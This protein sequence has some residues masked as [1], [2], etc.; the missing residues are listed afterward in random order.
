MLGRV[1]G[2]VKCFLSLKSPKTMKSDWGDWKKVSCRG[3]PIFIAVGV[4]SRTINLR[5][6]NGLCYKLT[7][8]ALFTYLILYRVEC[9][10]STVLSSAYFTHFSNLNRSGTNADIS[11][12]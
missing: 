4:A 11:K 6:F 1:C 10:I 12:L 7:K 9:M 5:S 2:L 3:K 8:I